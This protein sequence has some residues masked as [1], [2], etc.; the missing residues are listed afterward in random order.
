MCLGMA[1]IMILGK[2]SWQEEPAVD[3]EKEERER[4]EREMAAGTSG[5]ILV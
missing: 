4:R 2:N 3:L 1:C 5:L